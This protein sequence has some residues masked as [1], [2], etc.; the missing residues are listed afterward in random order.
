MSSHSRLNDSETRKRV[1][2]RLSQERLDA[3]DE[4]VEAGVYP[5]RSEALRDGVD[6][7]ID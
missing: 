7:L 1:T 3:L 4:L 2:V 6:E 5:N